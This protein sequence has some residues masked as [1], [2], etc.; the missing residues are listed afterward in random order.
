MAAP[1][2]QPDLLERAQALGLK[3][4]S[5]VEGLRVGDHRSPFHG[6]SVEFVQHRPYVPG[7]DLRYLDWKSYARSERYLLK[8]FEQETN[9]RGYLLLDVSQSMGYGDGPTNKLEYAKVLV[10]TLAYVILHQRDSVSLALVDS[11]WRCR[12]PL[13]GQPGHWQ[14]ILETLAGA[15]PHGPTALAPRLHELA[16]QVQRRGLVFLIS[17]CLE[18]VEPLLAGLRHLRFQGHD[19]T[20]FQVL[21][22]EELQFPI[23]GLVRFEDLE[24]RRHLLTRPEVIRPAYLRALERY[25]HSLRQGCEA[26]RCDYVLLDTSRPLA[27]A[28]SEYLVRRPRLQIR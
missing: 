16:Q 13:S 4:R 11:G 26:Y 10:A 17:D 27:V 1:Y 3:A 18:A 28:L 8:Q 9:F 12:L 7:D 2:L 25:L 23:E 24:T 21:H 5:L 6:Y 14:H 22:P 20:V 15:E 19:V